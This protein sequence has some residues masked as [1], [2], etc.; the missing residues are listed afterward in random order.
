M[1]K[2]VCKSILTSVAILV[3]AYLLKGVVVKD[4]LTAVWVAIVLGLLN[5]FVKPILVVL[6]IPITIITLGLF[7]LVINVVIVK[8][9]ANIV[10]GFS[11]DTWYTALFF[12]IIVSVVSSVLDGLIGPHLQNSTNKKNY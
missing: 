4:P 12:S 1:I 6:T 9:V 7:L 2:F 3:A 10:P 5:T 11:V 8:W